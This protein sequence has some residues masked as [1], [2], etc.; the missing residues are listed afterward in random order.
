MAAADRR[1]GLGAGL[2]RSSVELASLTARCDFLA[3]V[4]SVRGAPGACCNV[5]SPLLTHFTAHRRLP[6]PRAARGQQVD[7][8]TSA[9]GMGSPLP[10]LHRDWGAARSQREEYPRDARANRS[11]L[12]RLVGVDQLG[13]RSPSQAGSRFPSSDGCYSQRLIVVSICDVVPRKLS[14]RSFGCRRDAALACARA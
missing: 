4:A 7:A 8:A 14:D 6:V 10:H 2:A 12:K 5:Y 9:P 11:T 3:G 1:Y 13:H